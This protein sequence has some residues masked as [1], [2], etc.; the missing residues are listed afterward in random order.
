MLYDLSRVE[1]GGL[2]HSMYPSGGSIPSIM[3]SHT[4][5]FFHL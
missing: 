5:H 4:V 3:P 2:I 1:S